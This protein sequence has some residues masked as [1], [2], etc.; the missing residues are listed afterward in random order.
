MKSRILGVIIAFALFYGCSD[1]FL[2]KS[3]LGALTTENFF[4]TENDAFQSVVAAYSDLKDYRYVWTIWCFGDVLSEDA[5]YSGSDDDVQAF[6]RMESYNYPADN[7]RILDRWQTLFRGVNKANQA[8]DG[9]SKMD[10]DLFKTQSKD[11]LLGEA[12]FLRAYY[13]H[14]LVVAFG[15][16]P[17]M[18]TTPT[19]ND[20][21]LTRTPV[22]Q[23]Y[24]QI[25][26]DLITAANYLPAKS[27]MNVTTDAGRITK[28]AANA[29]LSRVYLY[30]KKYDACKTASKAVFA[31]TDY[32]LVDNYADVFKPSG[33]YCSESILE[34]TQYDSPSGASV[35]TLNNN[36]NLHTLLMMPFGA[37][38]GYGVNQPTITL[39]KA[40]IGEGDSI[41]KHATML[42]AD[43]LRVWE[44]AANFAKLTRNR[45]GYYNEKFYLK[46]AERSLN[47]R[48][49]AT[50]IRLI[51]LPEIYLN[52]AEAC[53][54]QPTT[55]DG[56]DEARTYLNKVRTR[57]HLADKKS[58]GDALLDDIM[59]ERRLEFGGEGHRYWDMVRTGKAAT[60]FVSKGTFKPASCNLLPIPQAEIDA[61]GGSITQ[62]PR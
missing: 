35:G 55:G 36:G 39:A 52:Y 62:N 29:M 19:I 25:E 14:E 47:A 61:S 51:R 34:I 54:L 24:A 8:I 16:V 5:T 40:Y 59:L 3:K 57:V 56:E 30:E 53:T 2:N 11:R 22:D 1:D 27:A 20:K 32:R 18:T 43:S 58:T 10:V 28:A 9:I 46:P 12:M 44:T 45:T 38:Y 13:Y 33:E 41:R 6:A 7:P 48:N 50:N 23:V 42:T 17:L 21:T 37:T 15:A 31:E 4:V 60:A 26:K 49:N